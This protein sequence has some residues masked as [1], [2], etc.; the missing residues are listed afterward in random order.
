MK[1][2][3]AFFYDILTLGDEGTTLP[4]MVKIQ[5]GLHTETMSY[6]MEYSPKPLQKQTD[7]Q[8]SQ[9]MWDKY[10]IIIICIVTHL[11]LAPFVPGN[12]TLHKK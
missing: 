5:I 3:I 12:W 11:L 7:K 4:Q 10:K 2:K 6:F 1:P 8:N 9:Q